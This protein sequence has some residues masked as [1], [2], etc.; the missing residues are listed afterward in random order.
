MHLPTLHLTT[1]KWH[2]KCNKKQCPWSILSK[3]LHFAQCVC[4]FFLETEFMDKW[5]LDI[6]KSHTHVPWHQTWPLESKK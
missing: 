3:T 2:S 4:D 1:K 5:H 6:R